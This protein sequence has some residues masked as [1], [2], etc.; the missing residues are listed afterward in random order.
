VKGVFHQTISHKG[1]VKNLH[2]GGTDYRDANHGLKY[3]HLLLEVYHIYGRIH[4]NYHDE[5]AH[6]AIVISCI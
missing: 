6:M 2:L 1:M 5:K 4:I 3:Q